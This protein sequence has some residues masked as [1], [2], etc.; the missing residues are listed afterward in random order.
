MEVGFELR[1]SHMGCNC[2]NLHFT[3]RSIALGLFQ[4]LI[5]KASTDL[6]FYF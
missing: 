6:D 2:P 3:I 5:Q 1:H 4:F